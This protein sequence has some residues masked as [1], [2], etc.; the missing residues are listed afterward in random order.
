M[1]AEHSL[2][3]IYRNDQIELP[4]DWAAGR[5]QLEGLLAVDYS[6]TRVFDDAIYAD[7]Q[8]EKTTALIATVDCEPL[9]E[10]D[11]L[12]RRA[13]GASKERSAYMRVAHLYNLG[14][15]LVSLSPDKPTPVIAIQTTIEAG[16]FTEPEASLA[17]TSPSFLTPEQFNQQIFQPNSPLQP[18]SSVGKQLMAR[19]LH[20]E[21]TLKDEW[22]PMKAS[23]T[24]EEYNRFA[25]QT[26]LGLCLRKGVPVIFRNF[27]AI[28]HPNRRRFVPVA[29]YENA[30]PDAEAMFSSPLTR[31]AHF[32]NAANASAH[33]QGKR[34]PYPEAA[35]EEI[36]SAMGEARPRIFHP[37]FRPAKIGAKPEK[38]L[39]PLRN[40]NQILARDLQYG[41]ISPELQTALDIG[42]LSC[43]HVVRILSNGHPGLAGV[44]HDLLAA[45]V[46]DTS[47]MPGV[48]SNFATAM[49]T[50]TNQ[51][52]TSSRQEDGWQV[53]ISVDRASGEQ[54][55][56]TASSP[57]EKQ[58]QRLALG[59]VIADVCG[60]KE[61]YG[62]LLTGCSED[63]PVQIDMKARLQRYTNR[64]TH[65]N[66]RYEVK[67]KSSSY[68]VTVHA[69]LPEGTRSFTATDSIREIA[70]AR[71]ALAAYNSRQQRALG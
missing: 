14:R 39:E 69:D 16:V 20:Y 58:A 21:H 27:D 44:R 8:P 4:S 22:P 46:A 67:D 63:A 15:R 26:L 1:Y 62:Q 71:A 18:Y 56:A 38:P 51:T 48:F 70:E 17:Q 28:G 2:D 33:L 6:N 42:A 60:L 43:K 68:E 65:T 40:I 19:R 23:D 52:E 45:L 53:S 54:V 30:H 32:V 3:R 35:I 41:E 31:V 25:N 13:D 9:L 37:E 36:T 47:L 55:T 61:A 11:A 66:P 5:Q 10:V 64:I 50:F 24:V 59:G 49:G 57:N 7:Q 12:T 29:E 34:I